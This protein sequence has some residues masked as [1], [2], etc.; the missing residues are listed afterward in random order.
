MAGMAIDLKCKRNY[1]NKNKLWM[2]HIPQ[3]S[4]VSKIST[5]L[6]W[7]KYLFSNGNHYSIPNFPIGGMSSVLYIIQIKNLHANSTWNQAN[8]F[9]R[10]TNI[11]GKPP[12]SDLS[13]LTGIGSEGCHMFLGSCRWPLSKA[14]PPGSSHPPTQAPQHAPPHDT[15]AGPRPCSR[16]PPHYSGDLSHGLASDTAGKCHHHLSV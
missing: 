11:I 4:S 1:Y 15:S 10:N 16:T 5:N 12:P 8:W 3:L 7:K 6:T 13:K 9:W 14:R 2:N